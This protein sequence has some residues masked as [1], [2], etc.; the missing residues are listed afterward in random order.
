MAV[1]VPQSSWAVIAMLAIQRAGGACVPLDPKA[2]AQRWWEIISRTGISTVVT[3]ETK[4]HIM[5]S[6]L[7]G[8]QVVSADGTEIDQHHL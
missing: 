3:S 5:S 8:L 4:K 1:C 2:P 7:P 6:Q